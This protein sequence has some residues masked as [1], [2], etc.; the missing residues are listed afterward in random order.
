MGNILP[1]LVGVQTCT[2]T[3]E[4]NMAVTQEDGNQFTDLP[5]DPAIP[6]L[7]LYPKDASSYHRDI[8]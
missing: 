2:A 3:K 1:L 5:Q 6:L 4:I 7:D 8:C